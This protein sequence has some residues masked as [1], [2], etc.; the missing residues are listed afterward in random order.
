[1]TK[2]ISLIEKIDVRSKVQ[3][4]RSAALTHS[5]VVKQEGATQGV[6]ISR[7]PNGR[8]MYDTFGCTAE[9]KIAL[10]EN[11]KYLMQR[12]LW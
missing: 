1:M 7:C 6:F 4:L 11:T 10:L 12:D 2:V 5:K 3:S 8:I 9:D